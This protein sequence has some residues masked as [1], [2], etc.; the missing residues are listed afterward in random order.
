MKLLFAAWRANGATEFLIAGAVVLG[1][2]LAF[3]LLRF[4]TARLSRALAARSAAPLH[5]AMADA[6]SATRLWLLLPVALYIGAGALELPGR[7]HEAIGN[8]AVIVLMLQAGGWAHRFIGS[9]FELKSTR[10][11][12]ADGEAVTAMGLISFLARVTV[13]TITL[14]LVLNHLG[15]NITALVA[16][17]GIGGVAVALA[18]QNVLGDLLASLAI[19]LDKPFVVGDFIV[20]DNLRGEVERVGIKTTRIRSLDGEQ[21]IVSNADLLKSRIRNLRRMTRRRVEF[22]VGIAYET[23]PEKLARVPA[24]LRGIVQAQPRAGFDRAHFKQLGDSALVFEVVYFVP[25]PDTNAYMDMQQAIN[26]EIFRRFAAEG[27]EFAY[28]TQTVHVRAPA[29]LAPPAGGA[30]TT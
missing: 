25:D 24:L 3:A 7:V 29:N 14:L 9:W 12:G 28:P 1:V 19:V 5:A 13:W 11:E 10:R 30:A 6:A 27:I 26:L 20:V 21:L 15:V 2:L 16:G 4:V 22:T 17:L 18:L 8:A 23:A